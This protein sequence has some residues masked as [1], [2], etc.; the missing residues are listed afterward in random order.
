MNELEVSRQQQR[1]TDMEAIKECVSDTLSCF[2]K[3]GFE[4]DDADIYRSVCALMLAVNGRLDQIK[5]GL[6]EAEIA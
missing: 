2:V 1:L 5:N 6:K 4:R 3:N